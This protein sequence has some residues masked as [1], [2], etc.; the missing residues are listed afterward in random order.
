MG[1]GEAEDYFVSID[2]ETAVND[3]T[4]ADLQFELAPNPATNNV[5]LSFANL[6]SKVNSISLFDLTGNVVLNKSNIEIVDKSTEFDVSTLSKGLYIVKIQTDNG[7]FSKT[8]AV[9]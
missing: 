8:L 4:K 7:V 1:S 3:E 6:S 5:T 2:F 9:E